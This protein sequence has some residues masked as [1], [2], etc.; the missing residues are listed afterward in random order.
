MK[1]AEIFNSHQELG[2]IL[3]R[4]RLSTFQ[5]NY[6][7]FAENYEKEGL[8]YVEFLY[9]LCSRENEW[10]DKNQQERILSSSKLPRNKLLKDFQI[11]RIPKLS[12]SLIE[13]L[14]TGNFMDH[15]ENI[16][17][18]GNPGTGKTHLAIGLAREWCLA[19]RHVLFK[20][21]FQLV[22]ELNQAQSENSLH[23]L[24]GRLDRIDCLIID[25]ISYMPLG[26]KNKVD[27]LFQLIHHRY[28]NKSLVIT[29]NLVFSQWK[30]LFQDE[31]ASSAF[32][33][34]LVHH[35]EILELNATSFRAEQAISR[36][37]ANTEID[38]TKNDSQ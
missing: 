22:E 31:L 36:K 17:I 6:Q 38:G 24:L 37:R 9:E 27:V 25:D 13:R 20:H 14:A 34:R 15:A 2:Q 29:S 21:A 18:F 23:K 30:S 12:P 7:E 32:I 26:D 35:S 4:L 10:R 11:N 3:Y 16:L 5:K 1:K 8:G 28:E 33:D 19:G